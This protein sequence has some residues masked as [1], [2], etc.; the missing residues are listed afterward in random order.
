MK[1]KKLIKKLY[2]ALLN[3]DESTI[4]KLRK[5]EFKKIFKRKEEGKTFNSKWT[6]IK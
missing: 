4:D 3:H 1:Q 6:I 5:K 2:K